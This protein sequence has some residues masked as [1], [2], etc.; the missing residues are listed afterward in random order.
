[1]SAVQKAAANTALRI[2]NLFVQNCALKHGLPKPDGPDL[3]GDEEPAPTPQP[4]I[5]NNNIPAA[6]A[7]TSSPS[8]GTAAAPAGSSL[9]RK[10]APFLLSAAGAG[11]P[12]GGYA[13]WQAMHPAPTVQPAEPSVITPSDGDLLQELQRQ[14]RHL[15]EGWPNG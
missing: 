3:I 8:P 13:L 12:V 9:L 4:I 5:V 6:T 11:L 14:G 7:A 15:P 2:A 10:A 1:M